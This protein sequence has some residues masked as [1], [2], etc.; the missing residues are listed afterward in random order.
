[1]LKGNDFCEKAAFSH[2]V[3]TQRRT[4][5]MTRNLEQPLTRA[6]ARRLRLTRPRPAPKNHPSDPT[7]MVCVGR[8]KYHQIV[9]YIV[10]EVC[11][12]RDKYHQIV[13][14]IVSEEADCSLWR[15]WKPLTRYATS[16]FSVCV[17]SH[18]ISNKKQPRKATGHHPHIHQPP[19]TS[20]NRQ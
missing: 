12:G 1:M 15:A 6:H 2:S 18:Q 9:Q 4:K 20:L 7:L 3:N 5:S 14:Y 11:V 10:S 13:Q 19:A 17:Q 8:D 16:I